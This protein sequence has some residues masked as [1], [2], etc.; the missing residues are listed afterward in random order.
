MFVKF[1]ELEILYPEVRLTFQCILQT[2]Y[3]QTLSNVTQWAS[4]DFFDEG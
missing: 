4:F 3:I 2:I 1:E